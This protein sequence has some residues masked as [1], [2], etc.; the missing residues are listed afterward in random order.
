[1]TLMQENN[2]FLEANSIPE[3]PPPTEGIR[4]WANGNAS[5]LINQESLSE[6]I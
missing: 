2:M 3:Y 5:Q 1:M 4:A 6:G